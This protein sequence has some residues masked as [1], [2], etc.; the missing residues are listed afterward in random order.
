[1]N[2][3]VIAYTA[4]RVDVSIILVSG[5]IMAKSGCKILSLA[6]ERRECDIFREEK[7]QKER[8]LSWG[9]MTKGHLTERSFL[10]LIQCEKLEKCV[11]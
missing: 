6:G 1:M 5:K 7:I 10:D 4:R 3:Y 8:N 11:E 9:P 2:H